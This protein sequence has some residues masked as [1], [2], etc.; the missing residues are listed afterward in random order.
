M[1]SE[2]GSHDGA[3]P[4]ANETTTPFRFGDSDAQGREEFIECGAVE[5]LAVDDDSVDVKERC[6]HHL[7]PG[8]VN[9]PPFR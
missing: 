8:Y 1:F 2:Q 3:G 5:Q 4:L 9:R 7:Q 6:L